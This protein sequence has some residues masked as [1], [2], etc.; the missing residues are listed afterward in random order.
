MHTGQLKDERV[1]H[2][3]MP[4]GVG[5]VGMRSANSDSEFGVSD[6]IPNPQF[7]RPRHK[8]SRRIT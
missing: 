6:F 4:L 5:E 7:R 8:E 2:D 3:Q 1:S